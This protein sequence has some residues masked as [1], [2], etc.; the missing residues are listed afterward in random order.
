M[1]AKEWIVI[2]L[3]VLIILG[4]CIYVTTQQQIEYKDKMTICISFTALFATFGGAYLGAKISGENARKIQKEQL[5]IQN[6]E[7]NIEN[8][9]EY[10][11]EF[12]ILSRDMS[13]YNFKGLLYFIKNMF[14]IRYRTHFYRDL[15]SLSKQTMIYD[16]F[17]SNIEK[18]RLFGT[19]ISSLVIKDTNKYL[20]IVKL[21]E[22]L[23]TDYRNYV[24]KLI[25]RNY[26]KIEIDNITDYFF[27]YFNGERCVF[28]LKFKGGKDKDINIAD[29][30]QNCCKM[31]FYVLKF[32][33][34]QRKLYKENK[35]LKYRNS[36]ELLDYI[37]NLY[38]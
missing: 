1:K 28:R 34:I 26:P 18:K 27:L 32:F 15:R 11:K 25:K 10:L 22:S 8:N 19:N 20:T 5:E 37:N 6:L 2:I 14:G 38:Q 13:I 3:M 12:E 31:Y 9:F 7:K 35:K 17:N 24:L 36:K 16:T 33:I 23:Y 21:L 4:F 29:I 30:H